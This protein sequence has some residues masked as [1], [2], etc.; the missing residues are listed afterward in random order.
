MWTAHGG[1]TSPVFDGA[2]HA[3]LVQSAQEHGDK[4]TTRGLGNSA[5]SATYRIRECSRSGV[6]FNSRKLD[7][8]KNRRQIGEVGST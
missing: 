8:V 6:R 1:S 7:S 4:L 2:R 3:G 5:C